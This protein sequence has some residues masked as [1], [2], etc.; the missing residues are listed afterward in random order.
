MSQVL[1]KHFAC[2]DP[3]N[4]YISPLSFL[5][6]SPHF[7]DRE[8]EVQS[9][10]GS[11]QALTDKE[12]RSPSPDLSPLFP[13]PLIPNFITL[14]TSSSLFYQA[15]QDNNEV[16]QVLQRVDILSLIGGGQHR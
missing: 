15:N 4:L 1:S 2:I 13:L 5:P 7:I 10:G 11:S 9:G 12:F 6:L 3:L 16:Q 8:T 14:I